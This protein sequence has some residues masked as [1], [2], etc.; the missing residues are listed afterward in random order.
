MISFLPF[1]KIYRLFFGVSDDCLFAIRTDRNDFDRNSQLFFQ[2]CQVSIE[3]FRK[4]VFAGHFCHVCIPSGNFYV[5]RFNGV[6]YLKWKLG[7]IF[8]V[9]FVC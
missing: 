8:S 5:N 2:E 4:F 1:C 9:D 6:V 7:G 3:F